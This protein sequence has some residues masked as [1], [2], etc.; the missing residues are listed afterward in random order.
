MN[1]V[2]GP[3]RPS[4]RPDRRPPARLPGRDRRLLTIQ[5]FRARRRPY[6]EWEVP[7]ASLCQ[8]VVTTTDAD[9]RMSLDMVPA[10]CARAA[11]PQPNT[12][13]TASRSHI[14]RCTT[15]SLRRLAPL[16]A[17]TFGEIFASTS[18]PLP[19]LHFPDERAGVCASG[20]RTFASRRA[21]CGRTT[22]ASTTTALTETSPETRLAGGGTRVPADKRR[23]SHSR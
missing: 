14:T 4:G 13:A 10:D 22:G 7:S 11:A 1:S 15:D 20:G 12:A 18:A 17:R 21:G 8:I 23:C 16:V 5:E 2:I 9:T 6:P 3:G 19:R